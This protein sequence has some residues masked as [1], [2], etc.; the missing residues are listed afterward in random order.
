MTTAYIGIGANLGDPAV[1]VRWAIASLEKLGPTT[2]S[3]LYRAEP[4]GDP[5]QPWYVNAV[6]A[7]E[8]ERGP[9]ALLETLLALERERGRPA[10]RRRWSARVLDLDLILYGSTCLEEPGLS[11]PHPGLA[12]RRFW[13]E[14]LCELAAE[15]VDPRSGKRI[16]ELLAVLDDPLQVEKLPA[17][18]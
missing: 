13:L 9:R 3:A 14:P 8:T 15:A 12:R 2:A 17:T 16:R 4:L 6:V 18:I 7:H 10:Q 1:N 11:V 5:S